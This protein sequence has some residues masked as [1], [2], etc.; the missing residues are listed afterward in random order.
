MSKATIFTMLGDL[1]FAIFGTSLC[2]TC[3]LL[4]VW[5]LVHFGK[6]LGEP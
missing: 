2:M 3:A 5:S 4:L 6:L 1:I